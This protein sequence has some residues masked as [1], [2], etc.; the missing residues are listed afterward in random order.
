MNGTMQ[1]PVLVLGATGVVG[2][3]VVQAAVD[4]GVPVVAVARNARDLDAL[5]ARHPHG[6]VA[7]IVGSVADDA[8]SAQLADRLRA[9]QRPL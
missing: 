8:Q 4:A 2:R 9:L 7:T 6:A 1:P 3:G 5:A